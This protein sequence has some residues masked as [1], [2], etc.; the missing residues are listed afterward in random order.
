MIFNAAGRGSQCEAEVV[1][2]QGWLLLVN[3]N[4]NRATTGRGFQHTSLRRE[5]V[6]SRLVKLSLASSPLMK[7]GLMGALTRR[8][9][10]DSG[11]ASDTSGDEMTALVLVLIVNALVLIVNALKANAY[12]TIRPEKDR[13]TS[14]IHYSCQWQQGQAPPDHPS[15]SAFTIIGSTNSYSV[16]P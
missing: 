6:I 4:L 3:T 10:Y 12:Q 14:R 9:Y 7:P 2:L 5:A 8:S 13:R 16:Y 1:R 11:S 15:G